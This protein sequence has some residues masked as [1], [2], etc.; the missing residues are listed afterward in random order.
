MSL[1]PEIMEID[2]LYVWNMNIIIHEC[3]IDKKICP[4]FLELI[5]SQSVM[6]NK[7]RDPRDPKPTS[8]QV[9]QQVP[10]QNIE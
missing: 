6:R 9:T 10:C 1:L 2:I 3:N 5:R 7:G 4:D 8:V